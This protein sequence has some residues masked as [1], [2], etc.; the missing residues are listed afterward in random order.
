MRHL[1]VHVQGTSRRRRL[2][3]LLQKRARRFGR[4]LD[5]VARDSAHRVLQAAAGIAKFA[6]AHAAR[7]VGCWP[8][9][10]LASAIAS[11]EF[12]P[13]YVCASKYASIAATSAAPGNQAAKT[14]R[15]TCLNENLWPCRF[16]VAITSLKLKQSPTS[17]QCSP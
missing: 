4:A 13:R 8:A 6:L 10:L 3:N 12:E 11:R 1:G 7:F 16:R 14:S 9:T 15:G 2:G 17:G 5:C